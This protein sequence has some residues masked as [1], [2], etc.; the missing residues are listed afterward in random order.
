MAYFPT[1]E[2]VLFGGRTLPPGAVTTIGPEFPIDGCGWERIRIYMSGVLAAVATPFGDGLFRFIKGL[3][4][5][6][7]RGD[8]IYDNVP[9]MAAYR[10]NQMFYHTD[11]FHDPMLAAGGTFTAVLDLPL[12]MPFLNRPEDLFLD[13]GR[14][15][16]IEL[17]IAT[18]AL[19]VFAPAA[20]ATCPVTFGMSLVKTLAPLGK[21]ADGSDDPKS[22]PVN[23][24]YYKSYQNI[25][26]GTALQWDLESSMDLGLFGFLVHNHDI[27]LVEGA[28]PFCHPAAGG[29]DHIAQITFR[30]S[31]RPYINQL[32]LGAF[33]KKRRELCPVPWYDQIAVPVV[34]TELPTSNIGI[35]PHSFVTQGS[36]NE[37]FATGRKSLLQLS[38]TLNAGAG[39]ERADLL[40][41]GQR[42]LR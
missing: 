38:F 42:G 24:P 6:T 11:P 34:A 9:G 13:T 10:L 26:T 40:V 37:M 25:A 28:V 23:A 21:R 31:L 29:V 14:Y 3:N 39:T 30:D 41:W 27:L 15:S 33:Q 7:N 22:K 17:Q 16:Y 35:Y 2:V 18:G 5:R 19:A 32:P 1:E 20:P 4:L 36:I 12:G 8:V